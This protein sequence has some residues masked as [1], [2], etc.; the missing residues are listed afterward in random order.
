MCRSM[1]DLS[2]AQSR[3]EV[4]LTSRLFKSVTSLLAVAGALT[5]APAWAEDPR[6]TL[7]PPVK[8]APANPAIP[9]TEVGEA[10][11]PTCLESL[12]LTEPQQT[13][14]KEIVRDYD[15]DLLVVWKQFG[16]CYLET[17]RTESLLLAAIED[18]LT[19]PQR[20]QVRDQR[21]LTAKRQKALAGTDSKPNQATSKPSSAVEEGLAVEGVTLSPEQ[22]DTADKLQAKCLNHLRSLN[23]DIQGLHTRL[24]S[25]E[26][27]K[28]V[29]I[30]S[31]LTKEQLAQLREQRQTAPVVQKVTARRV[32]PLATESPLKTK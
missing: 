12:T 22:Q 8:A 14:I 26:A 24:V 15:A 2:A 4:G 13:R 18:N 23:R 17:V 27:D 5:L 1:T 25:L 28:L 3:R 32:A 21:R 6:P 10:A 30:E 7:A 19:E 20:K 29:E 16:D 11:I 9:A 31:V